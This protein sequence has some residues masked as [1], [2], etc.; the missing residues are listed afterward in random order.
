MWSYLGESDVSN[1]TGGAE[2]KYLL[3]VCVCVREMYR[4]VVG[5]CAALWVRF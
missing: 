5:A 4:S 1:H 3:C 2:E